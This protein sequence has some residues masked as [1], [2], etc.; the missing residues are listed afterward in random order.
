MGGEICYVKAFMSLHN[1]ISPGTEVH[2]MLQRRQGA[3]KPLPDST[4]EAKKN[5]EMGLINVLNSRDTRLIA[6]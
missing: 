2:L 3:L 5:K 1:R 6:G 4:Q